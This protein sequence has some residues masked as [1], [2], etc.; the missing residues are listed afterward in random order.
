MA[1]H[2]VSG[3]MGGLEHVSVVVGGMS[4]FPRCCSVPLLLAG[5]TFKSTKRPLASSSCPKLG[6]G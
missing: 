6:V 4:A 2:Y 5:R 1:T 3:Q